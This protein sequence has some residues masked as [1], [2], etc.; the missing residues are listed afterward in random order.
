MKFSEYQALASKTD[1][2]PEGEKAKM[3][4]MLGLAG[5]AGSVLT[6]YKKFL[7]DGRAHEMKA[8]MQEELGDVLWYVANIAS[9]FGL[10]LDEV[11]AAN[12][13]K[14]NRWWGPQPD[15]RAFDAGFPIWEQLPSVFEVEMTPL[16]VGEGA[17]V[18][19]TCDSIDVGDT[20]T[21]NAHVEDGY[22]FH[23]I[24]HFA[25]AA[26]LGWSPVTR[27]IFG[28]KRKSRPK[29]DEVEDGGRAIVIEEGISAFV[30][31]HAWPHRFQQATEVERSVLNTIRTMVKGLEV[32]ERTERELQR[33]ILEGFRVFRQIADAN[34]GLV[35]VNTVERYI[36]VVRAGPPPSPP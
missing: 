28:L 32:A 18:R 24:F 5:E 14:V 34:G 15:R 31:A 6:V 21:D 10:D 19:L 1:Q 13:T 9:K 12:V 29:F 8:S 26:I 30:F 35:V 27:S 11:A 17:A 3:L 7:R 4:P 16:A 20:L 22:R 23:D 36:D 25:Y 33:A 2:A